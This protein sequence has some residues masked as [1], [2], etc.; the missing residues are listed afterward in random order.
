MK[1]KARKH[2]ATTLWIGFL[3]CLNPVLKAQT[4]PISDTLSNLK[5]SAVVSPSKKKSLESI[6]TFQAEDSLYLDFTTK[7]VHLYNMSSIDM[8]NTHLKAYYVEVDLNTKVLF[9]KGGL[10]SNKK[11]TFKP[12]LEDNGDKYTADSMKYNSQSKKGKVYGLMLAQDEAF[13]HLGTVLK[14]NDGTFTGIDGKI[15]TCSDPHPH[16]YLSASKLKVMPNNKALF[17]P[18]NLVFAGIPTP[19]ALP[20]GLAPLKKGQRNGIIFPSL[21]FNSA[22]SSYY[23]Q[24]F[25]Y[26]MGL[27]QYS[28]IQITSDAY[29]NGDFRLGLQTQYYKRYKFRGTLALQISK[30]GN[31]AEET[32]PEY[33]KNNDF[34]IRSQFNI[35][36]KLYPGITFNGNINIVTGGFNRRNSRD[37]NSLS[38][39]QFT[40]SINY[41]R[42]MFQNKLN[43]SVSA[44][45]SQ[46]TATRDFGLELPTVNISASSIT[47]FSKK[48]GSN[49]SWYEQI[50]LS[51]NA[52]M[53][54]N[55]KTKDS[56]IFSEN[57]AQVFNTM[58]SGVKHSIPLITNV[59]LFNG[60]LNISP[61]INYNENW[62]LTTQ[63][64][65][66]DKTT[67]K[68]ITRDS[69]GF[70]RQ[71]G[72]NFSAS[73]NTNIYGTVSNIKVGKLRAI[74]HTINPSVGFSYVPEIDAASKGWTKEYTDTNGKIFKYNAFEKSPIGSL[75]QNKG[76]YLNFGLGNNLQGKKVVSKD[77]VGKEK[78]EKFNIIDQLSFNTSYNLFAD[79]FK[80][81]DIRASFNTVI[82]KQMRINSNASFSPYQINEK[83]R[84]LNE[85]QI[86]NGG[87]FA[88]FRN[89]DLNI[90]SRFSADMF[91]KKA[92]KKSTKIEGDEENEMKDIQNRPNNYYDFNIPWTLN[93]TYMWRYNAEELNPSRKVSSN[94]FRISGDVNLTPDW[95]IAYQSGYNFALSRIEGSSFSVIRD[96][97]CWQIEFNW[98]PDGFMKQWLFTLR[99]KSRL[100]QELK[101]NK[102]EYYNNPTLF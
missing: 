94:T 6:V 70:Y 20:F 90:N 54:N 48:N 62:H 91:K 29:F 56:I 12:V 58:S 98:I 72:Y 34:S 2:I 25:G 50:R 78:T 99:P 44:R 13:I 93:F 69:Q 7:T 59:K 60:A 97:H 65:E 27:G 76:G 45:H 68:I 42:M 67:K 51:Y 18:A 77:S 64:K 49:T 83:G 102:R 4:K 61:S 63:I 53:M 14:Q 52:T 28:D 32:S 37:L 30:F 40:S 71:Y 11:Y 23:L 35:D 24:N 96:L 86:S 82:F 38:N 8:D 15:T 46:N 85:F 16:F 41:G 3:F 88:R 55:I 36:P 89:V 74:R 19:L 1:E 66:Y 100:L 101:L 5:D 17:G 47:P 26:Y 92:T 9:A 39:N 21:G 73:A 10:D 84:L 75:F 87:K 95:K 57:Y 43:L 22:N 81:S 80:W 79:S 31:G 33:F